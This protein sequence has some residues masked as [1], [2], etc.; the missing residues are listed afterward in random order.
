[1]PRL[2]EMKAFVRMAGSGADLK[3]FGWYGDGHSNRPFSPAP[4]W[5][6]CPLVRHRWPLTS[7]N[8]LL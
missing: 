7:F 6:H 4:A 2:E 1:M 5:R 3:T 8:I